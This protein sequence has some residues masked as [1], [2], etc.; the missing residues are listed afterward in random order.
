MLTMRLLFRAI[1]L[2]ISSSSMRLAMMFS[3]DTAQYCP[4]MVKERV[5]VKSKLLGAMKSLVF[6]PEGQQP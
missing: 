2:V 6:S 3:A 4:P 1:S 5:D